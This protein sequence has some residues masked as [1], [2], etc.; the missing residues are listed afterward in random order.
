MKKILTSLL[1]FVMVLGLIPVIPMTSQAAA[2]GGTCG[3]NLTW[4]FN[5]STGTLTISG[6]GAMDN[7]ISSRAQWYS[8]ES[9]IKKVVVGQGV[10]SIGAYAFYECKGLTEIT[11]PDSVTFIGSSAF[12]WCTGLTEITIP[13]SVTSIR[14]R[15]FC[16]CTGLTEITIPDSVTSIGSSAFSVCTG[17][18]EITIPDSVTSIG[19]SAFSSCTG[20]TEITIP[21]SVTSIGDDAFS[22]CTGLTEITI[23]DSV[24]SIGSSAF[25][26]CTGLTKITIPD[27]VTS[28]GSS[29]FSSCT[30]LTEITIPDSVTSI[31]GYA[32][33]YCTGLTEITIPDSVTS[34]GYHAFSNCTNLTEI[35]VGNRV[36]SIEGHAFSYCT[37]L[38]TV[39]NYSNLSIVKGS[40]G[41]GYVGYYADNVYWY[42]PGGNCGY[43][44]DSSTG[45]LTI[46]GTGAMADYTISS[47]VPWDEYQPLIKEVIIPDGITSIGDYTFSDCTGLTE[48]TI[49]DSV[50]SIGRRAFCGCTGLTE[51]TI[52][53]SVTSI[54]DDAFS[55]CTGLT[56]ITVDS[57][58][59]VYHSA[60]NC[61]IETASKTLILGCKNSIIP[62]DGSV[63]A[64]GNFAFDSCTGLTEITIPDSVT[65]IGDYA[66]YWCTGLTEITI[67]D[68]VSSIGA[69]AFYWC[70]GLTEIT[71]SNNVTS[72]E[73]FAF[74]GCS[75][76][77][78]ITIPNRVTTIGYGAFLHC[79]KLTEITI[80][81]SVT[82]IGSS[83]F[84]GCTGLT[85]IT[86]SDSVTSI[87]NNAFSNCE[88]LKTVHNHSALPIVKGAD[89]YGKV[90]YYA[91]NVYWKGT[92]E[93]KC[94]D[95]LSYVLDRQTKI[96]T[97]T[98]TGAMFNYSSSVT[99][100]DSCSSLIEKV[101]I[102]QGVTSIGSSA[103]SGCTGLTE[104]VI[105]NSVISIGSSAFADCIGLTKVTVPGSVTSIGNQVFQNCTSVTLHVEEN[106]A[107]HKYGK[108]NGYSVYLTKRTTVAPVLKD[109]TS[110]AITLTP[111]EGCEY[112]IE[113]GTWQRSNV[114]SGL[115]P[116]TLYTFY[117]R[118]YG[119]SSAVD[120]EA[121][122]S[123]IRTK[124]SA[125]NPPQLESKTD[126]TVTLKT[127]AG[128]EYRM[129]DGA[130]QDSPLFENLQPT[131]NYQFYQRIKE[132]ASV[133]GSE[134]SIALTITTLSKIVITYN[135]GGGTNAP[136]QSEHFRADSIYISSSV[137]SKDGQVFMGWNTVED[138]NKIYH[139]G[140]QYLGTENITFYA[141]WLPSCGTC[142][143]SGTVSGS[144]SCGDCYGKG[145]IYNDTR[146][147][148]D[149]GSGRITEYVTG[150]YGTVSQCITCGSVRI[151]GSS[152]YRS[153]SDCGGDGIVPGKVDCSGCSGLGFIMP[154]KPVVLS[155]S[156]TQVTLLSVSGYEYSKDG[157]LWQASNVF[158]NLTPGTE[159][160][161]YQRTAASTGTLFGYPS[162]GVTQ[163][164]DK[165]VNGAAP[166]PPTLQSKTSTTV[167]LNQMD[168]V[169]Y[170]IASTLGGSIAWRNSPSFSA[171]SC[172]TTYYFY[173]RYAESSTHYTGQQPSSP[174]T[175]TTEKGI[176]SAPSAPQVLRYTHNKVTLVSDSALQYSRDGVTWQDSNVFSGLS[177]YTTYVFYVRYKE[178]QTHLTSPASTGVQVRTKLQS[179]YTVGDLDGDE[180]VTDAD[181]VYLLMYTFFPDDYEVDQDVDYNGDGVAT[182]ADAVY[183]LMYTFFPD[184]YPIE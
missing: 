45:V 121:S 155:F 101:V 118:Y 147:C 100:W 167:T 109:R 10:T 65:S 74:C 88:N 138:D 125:V 156:D 146:K 144:V 50:T 124:S 2:T 175:V 41:N 79:S 25:S 98:G 115:N 3:A 140:E 32:F 62:T 113:G 184:D 127:V 131:Q 152:G 90:G 154:Q 68:S 104:I 89:T 181:A 130:W 36:T 7:Y 105:P 18:T 70:T 49:P 16:G 17:L 158:T 180:E 95:N 166:V 182:D 72:I 162:V 23:P 56:K 81:D 83:A 82:S 94:G 34:I 114:F 77:T 122:S 160:T 132:S 183:L 59:T 102:E 58:N 78:E 44:F 171:L 86:I 92:S 27:S 40:S 26:H 73:E 106:T 61:L 150:Y 148:M 110:T 13:D 54:G 157:V 39:Y 57:G 33:Y 87:G 96:L 6:T 111:V 178:T 84:S 15:A 30:G 176:R 142:S 52:P 174:L 5:D 75:G 14:S 76:L 11:I 20:L 145:E 28:I 48:I 137:P 179:D 108:N 103:F 116:N 42:V 141:V 151:S 173:V 161:F 172:G 149:C 66:F 165:S 133:S 134:P 64:I 51:I 1:A 22:Y 159:Y 120:G 136:A 107:A 29:A 12:Y 21:D 67:P 43:D 31:G 129:G 38:K 119:T 53:D 135:A 117:Q 126:T 163:K 55:D 143:G 139:S 169:Q 93:G 91:D 112:K 177:P 24:T 99:P 8:Y 170:G 35:T 164:T 4:K 80:P 60:G 97:I 71:I 128:Y 46:T 19:S 37:R 85:E 153:C 69:Y 123:A 47:T 9:S 168:G 63:T